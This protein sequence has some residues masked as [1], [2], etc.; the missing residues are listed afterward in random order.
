MTVDSAKSPIRRNDSYVP[1]GSVRISHFGLHDHV[2][3]LPQQ[4]RT[5]FILPSPDAFCYWRQ[6][7]VIHLLQLKALEGEPLH[8]SENLR[9]SAAI[10]PDLRLRSEIP[11][12]ETTGTS[13]DCN[14]ANE[15]HEA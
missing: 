15:R 7:L 2:P 11:S 6:T 8:F 5:K 9:T 3:P 13:R 1:Q 4:T 14:H 12:H 10:K